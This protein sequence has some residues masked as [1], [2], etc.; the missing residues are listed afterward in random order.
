MKVRALSNGFANGRRI[1]AGTV[2]DFD[3]PLGKWMEKVTD[4]ESPTKKLEA[5]KA[6]RKS[7][8]AESEVI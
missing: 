6:T 8:P 4:G 1:R 7:P 3:G 2:F 5:S